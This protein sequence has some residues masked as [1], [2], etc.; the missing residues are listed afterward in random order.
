MRPLYLTP[1][2]VK[3]K[4]TGSAKISINKV[5]L[6]TISSVAAKK[7]GLAPGDKISI[8]Q[9]EDDKVN[10]FLVN[11]GKKGK[12]FELKP[13]FIGE[14]KLLRF[15]SA[16]LRKKLVD[17]IYDGKA[18]GTITLLIGASAKVGKEIFWAILGKSI[19]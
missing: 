14:V 18:S 13:F 15:N 9:D 10:F 16:G 17:G 2:T 11:L 3:E 7:I 19:I 1:D 4:A 5:G 6:F 8:V 12:G